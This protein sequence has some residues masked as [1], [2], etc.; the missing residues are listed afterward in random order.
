LG[1]WTVEKKSVEN[2]V[3]EIELNSWREFFD[4]TVNTFSGAPAYIYRG[5]SNYDWPLRS[6][7]DR[8]RARYP[9]RKNLT[10]DIPHFFPVPPISEEEQLKAF[11]RSIRGRRGQTPSTLNDDECWALGQHHGLATPLLDWTRFPFVALFFAF[12]E[13]SPLDDAVKRSAP[14]DRGVYAL[15]ISTIETSANND[16]SGVR[17]IS[18]EGDADYRLVSQGGIL[19]RMPAESDL[20]SYVSG[21]F[22][23]ETPDATL[24]KVKIPDND[25]HGCLVALDKMNINYMTLFPDIGGAAKYVNSLWQPGHENSLPYV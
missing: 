3:Q 7:L 25:R 12:A 4:L 1:Q 22:E 5:Q 8:L 24:I 17:I 9:E 11:R 19:L 6:S 2:G 21:R 13:E 20:E 16:S 18:P 23:G 10:C 15:S 14:A